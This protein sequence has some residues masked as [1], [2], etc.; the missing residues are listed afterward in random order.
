MFL[1]DLFCF[2]LIY[3]SIG[4]PNIGDAH[5]FN[6]LRGLFDTRALIDAL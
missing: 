3:M 6:A 5:G 2:I 1:F 4:D